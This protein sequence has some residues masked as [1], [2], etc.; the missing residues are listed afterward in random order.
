M[1]S[2]VCY[3]AVTAMDHHV[4]GGS[5]GRPTWCSMTYYYTSLPPEMLLELPK[6]RRTAA[7]VVL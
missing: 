7:V 4:A 3:L 2:G 5:G 1:A 6:P